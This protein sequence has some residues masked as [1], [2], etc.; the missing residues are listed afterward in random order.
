M[1]A[2]FTDAIASG[3]EAFDRGLDEAERRPLDWIDCLRLAP[4]IGR[5]FAGE[6]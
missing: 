6:S 3:F 4:Y 5:P 2:G 1:E